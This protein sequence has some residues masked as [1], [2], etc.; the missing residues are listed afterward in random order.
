MAEQHT[1]TGDRSR[2]QVLCD[3]CSRRLSVH[4]LFSAMLTEAYARGWVR[5]D[6]TYP[7]MGDARNWY[8]PLCVRL[9][10]RAVMERECC[11]DVGG[12]G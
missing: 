8:C 5:G 6:E 2:W 11:C 9:K 1:V 3:S 4:E 12:E 10:R 7:P